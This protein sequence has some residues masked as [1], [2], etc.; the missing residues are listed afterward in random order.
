MFS[1]RE[2]EQSYANSLF[3]LLKY[4]GIYI[5]CRNQEMYLSLVVT[6]VSK[7]SENWSGGSINKKCSDIKSLKRTGLGRRWF[8]SKLSV[9]F[10]CY[11]LNSACL[12]FKCTHSYPHLRVMYPQ[13][14]HFFGI[15]FHSV[16]SPIRSSQNVVPLL[17]ILLDNPLLP[18]LWGFPCWKQLSATSVTWKNKYLFQ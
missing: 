7:P 12:I 6:C 10:C 3:S 9:G 17:L 8:S 15:S 18:P 14:S 11:F 4:P 2:V 13:N 16:S 5:N 1:N